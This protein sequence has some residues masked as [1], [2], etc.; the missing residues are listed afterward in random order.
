[1]NICSVA[2]KSAAFAA[3]LFAGSAWGAEFVVSE[4]A[5]RRAAD[6]IENEKQ[7]HLGFL[8]TERSNPLTA[9]LERDFKRSTLAG[10][11]CLQ[12]ADRQMPITLRHSQSRV[13]NQ[14]ANPKL[15][16]ASFQDGRI[17]WDAPAGRPFEG[18]GL[19]GS[20]VVDGRVVRLEDAQ[21][22]AGAEAVGESGISREYRL[23]GGLLW[24]WNLRSRDGFIELD[25]CLD[26]AGDRDVTIGEWNLLHG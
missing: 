16:S 6:F 15:L 20:V 5:R 18:R 10:V 1:M 24:R 7:F 2:S 21:P 17:V 13:N 4:A 14:S 19:S 25:A 23:P 11:E 12:R 22:P 26:N 3:L 9:S 8:P